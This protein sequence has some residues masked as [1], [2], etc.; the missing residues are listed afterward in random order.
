[1]VNYNEDEAARPSPGERRCLGS[2]SQLTV[3]H[4]SRVCRVWLSCSDWGPSL[5]SNRRCHMR[6]RLQVR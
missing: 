1:M 5:A 4:L 2:F 3:S 6:S